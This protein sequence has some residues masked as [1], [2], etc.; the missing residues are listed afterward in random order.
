MTLWS[1]KTI[2]S[3]LKICFSKTSNQLQDPTLY[4]F[5]YQSS[6]HHPITIF[7]W[8][9]SQAGYLTVSPINFL[10]YAYWSYEHA[11]QVGLAAPKIISLYFVMVSLMASS[12]S[13]FVF[14]QFRQGMFN[15]LASSNSDMLFIYYSFVTPRQVTKIFLSPI[16]T[17]KNRSS[18]SLN[19]LHCRFSASVCSHSSTYTWRW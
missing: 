11:M 1:T 5:S 15:F 12:S 10:S 18:S 14:I 2:R 3:T 9:P 8:S 4:L 7:F 19:M 6:S 16:Y 17:S 13:S